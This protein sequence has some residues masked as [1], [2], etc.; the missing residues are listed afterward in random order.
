MELGDVPNNT[1]QRLKR[2]QK[3]TAALNHVPDALASSCNC[4]H[5]REN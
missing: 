1:Q 3:M 5:A 2:N 4:W